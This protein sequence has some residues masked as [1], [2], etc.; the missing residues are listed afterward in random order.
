[1]NIPV[2]FNGLLLRWTGYDNVVGNVERVSPSSCGEYVC[3]P[4]Y[5]GDCTKLKVDKTP[6][7]FDYCPGDNWVTAAQGSVVVTWDEPRATDNI[8]LKKMVENSG[9]VPGQV[10]FFFMLC[11]AVCIQSVY[12]GVGNF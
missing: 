4:G 8:G 5:V 6:P 7:R 9:Y 11:N 2:V 10:C 3:P 12:D 1:M